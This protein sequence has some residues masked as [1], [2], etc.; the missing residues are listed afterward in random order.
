VSYLGPKGPGRFSD[1]VFISAF[2]SELFLL[3]KVKLQMSLAFHPLM[4]GQSKVV[5]R[6]NSYM[7]LRCLT[8]DRL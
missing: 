1:T 7:Y 8:G 2:L 5:N 4:D 6:V 3:V